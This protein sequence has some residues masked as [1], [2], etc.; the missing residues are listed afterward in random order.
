MK[1]NI[2]KRICRA[3]ILALFCTFGFAAIL[4]ALIVAA[5]CIFWAADYFDRHVY[6]L[7]L[8]W[9]IL[10]V[11]LAFGISIGFSVEFDPKNN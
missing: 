3:I 7:G 2:L 5:F 6:D 1:E 10:I 4:A 9:V 8:G 11:A